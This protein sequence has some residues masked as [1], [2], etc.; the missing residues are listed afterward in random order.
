M[1]ND[2]EDWLSSVVSG[3]ATMS[4]RGTRWVDAQGGLDAVVDAAK[5]R[6]VHIVQLTD[7][8]GKQLIA[9]SLQPFEVL[10]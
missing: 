4:Q 1:A 10:C 5:A 9:A 2:L 6:G 3:E 8:Q 7:D